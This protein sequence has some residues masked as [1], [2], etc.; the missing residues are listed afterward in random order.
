MKQ[1]L[2]MNSIRISALI[3]AAVLT[4]MFLFSCTDNNSPDN[5][6]YVDPNIGGVAYL[7][8]PTYPTI[9]RPNQMIRMV[10]G[11]KDY[12]DDQ[13]S[14]F[15]LQLVGHRADDVMRIMPFTTE[16]NP[17]NVPVSAWDQEHETV[18]PYYYKVWLEDFDMDV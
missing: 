9:Q 5:L 16:H 12:L 4:A 8:Q 1:D 10:P 15:P 18:R 6:D 17:V 2:I 14:Y 7:L 3:S 11:R 13:I